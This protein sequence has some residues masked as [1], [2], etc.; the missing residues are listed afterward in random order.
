MKKEKKRLENFELK[1]CLNAFKI[2]YILF[3][4]GY[5]KSLFEK[6]AQA[7]FNEKNQIDFVLRGCNCK[8]QQSTF[9]SI[10]V[11]VLFNYSYSK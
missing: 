3:L 11:L 9:R 4:S 8:Q 2:T 10:K 6:V 7:I 1:S 5:K